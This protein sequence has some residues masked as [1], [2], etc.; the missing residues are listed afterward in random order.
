M[1]LFQILPTAEITGHPTFVVNVVQVYGQEKMMV[2]REID[3]KNVSDPLLPHEVQCDVACL[4]YDT[5]NEKSF[6]YAA[7]IYI[8]SSLFT[9][10]ILHFLICTFVYRNILLKVKFPFSLWPIKVTQPRS[11]KSICINLRH[12][13]QNTKFFHRIHSV[14][15]AICE[16]M[17]S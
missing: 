10:F 1:F 5:T 15:R 9:L 13:V 14:L 16:K 12:F 6:E 17:F 3:I 11:D 2:L 8:V 4:L 7:R